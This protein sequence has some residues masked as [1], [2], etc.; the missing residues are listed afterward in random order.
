MKRHFITISLIVCMF[1]T[2]GVVAQAQ[3]KISWWYENAEP[4]YEKALR[5][6]MIDPFNKAHPDIRL[7]LTIEPDLDRV[8]RTAV[9]AN[10]GP[11]I[12]M[13]PGP[14]YAQEYA[15][16]GHLLPLNKYIK[17]YKW[18][19]MFIPMMLDISSVEGKV[20]SVPKTYEAMVLFY[21]KTLFQKNSWKVPTNISELLDVC[22]KMQAKGIIPFA[23]GNSSWRGN[24][25]H[26]VGLFLNHYAGPE[27]VYKALTGQL[28]WDD[29]IFIDAVKMLND[30]YQKGWIGG[31]NYFSLANEDFVTLLATGK[32]GMSMIGTWGF[33][34]M[35]EYFKGTGNDWDW[36][37][38]PALR[39]GVPAEFYDLG[40]G[41]TLS[42][43]ASSKNSDAAAEAINW[44]F[45]DPK[46]AARMNVTWQGEWNQPITTTTM[47]DFPK[48]ADPRYARHV[49]TVA[50]AAASGNYGYTTW[51]FWPVKTEQ[52]IIEG[53]EQVWLGKI[54]PAQYMQKVQTLFAEERAAGSVPPIPKRAK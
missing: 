37:P 53:I 34:W 50:K 8:L 28:R 16:A 18:D 46:R 31:S 44:L 24:N 4:Q 2:I 39:S 45:A 13:T 15:K 9:L 48:E 35:N 21:N 43:N 12:V 47:S 49:E 3:T 36:A 14:T 33:Q 54:T 10:S 52:W 30:F 1:F 40:I 41:T 22:K 42:I 29:P 5:E 11:D 20:Y 32:A 19:K 26:Y 6:I 23:Q 27:N 51:T 7:E 25:E 38:F 17:L